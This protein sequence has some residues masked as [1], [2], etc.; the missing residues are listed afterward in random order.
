MSDPTRDA[1][2]V[3]F[4][5]PL[6]TLGFILLGGLLDRMFGWQPVDVDPLHAILVGAGLVLMALFIALRAIATFRKAEEQVE[7]WTVTNKILDHG[8]YSWTRNPMYLGMLLL[9]LGIG[10]WSRNQGILL[11][12]PLIGIVLDHHVIKKEEAYLS[13]KF[14]AVYDDYRRRV[15]RWL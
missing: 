3:R 6:M 4:P 5:P 11:M 13:A 15:R 2:N 7:P 9:A 1:A 14:G 8:I 10:I 12:V